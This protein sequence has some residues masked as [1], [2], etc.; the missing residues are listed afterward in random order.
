MVTYKKKINLI[1]SAHPD[2]EI[3]G[4]G[5]TL[6][7]KIKNKEDVYILYVSDG[8]SSRN[9]KREM[10]LKKKK[11]RIL[12]AKKCSKFIGFKILDFLDLKD[13]SLDKYERLQI[14]KKIEF[15]IKKI[16]PDYV[17]TH[18]YDDLNIDHRIVFDAT[19]TATRPYVNK[20]IKEINLFEV[21]S[22]S[23]YR[24]NQ[25]KPNFYIDISKEMKHKIKALKIYSNQLK[26]NPYPLSLEAIKN[27][28]KYRG[29]YFDTFYAEAFLT[30]FRKI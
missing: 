10:L 1:I 12:K 18:F 17:F 3:I 7:K 8:E 5:G 9:Y 15:Y 19:I 26:K 23:S 27:L 24:T 25:F 16:K 6:V 4:M 22:S 11:D 21:N 20:F 30:F 2:D 13:N 14:V 28:A 29:N